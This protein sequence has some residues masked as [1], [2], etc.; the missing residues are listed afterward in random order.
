[1]IGTVVTALIPVGSML[2][3]G[4]M[5]TNGL[6]L[7][8]FRNELLAHTGEIE[9]ALALGAAPKESVARYIQSSFEASL[10]PP[11]DSLRSLG[12]VWIPG[13]MPGM[14]LSGAKPF[15]GAIYQFV[16]L[17]MMLAAS[18]LTS[19]ASTLLIRRHAF[20]PAEQLLVRPAAQAPNR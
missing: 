11:I 19:L 15:Y 7:N 14:L 16:T 13:L 2:I 17:A 1:L 10:I 12:I 9:A 3:A 18:S 8:R 5:N 20:T 4:A 6:A